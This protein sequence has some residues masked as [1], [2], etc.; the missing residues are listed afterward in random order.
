MN[1]RPS[2]ESLAALAVIIGS[3]ALQFL[4]YEFIGLG[5]LWAFALVWG[6]ATLYRIHTE[7]DRGPDP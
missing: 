1:V 2:P 4:G 7:N 6:G 5:V 3:T